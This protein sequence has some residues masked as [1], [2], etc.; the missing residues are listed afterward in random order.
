MSKWKPGYKLTSENDKLYMEYVDL[1]PGT[2][3]VFYPESETRFFQKKSLD[4]ELEFKEGDSGKIE[5]FRMLQFFLDYGF[6]KR[7]EE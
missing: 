2:K 4:I 7:M 1:N 3:L 6:M 5:G